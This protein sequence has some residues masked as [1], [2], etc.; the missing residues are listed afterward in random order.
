M[1]TRRR[2]LVIV[3]ALVAAIVGVLIFGAVSAKGD[4]GLVSASRDAGHP[5]TVVRLRVDCGFCF[6]PCRG[7]R[8]HRHPAGFAKGPC[9]LDGGKEVP[10]SFAVSLLPQDR[11]EDL[12]SCEIHHHRSCPRPKAAPRHRP[13][14]YL[15]DALPPPGGNN[16]ESGDLPRY[17]LRFRIPHLPA[18]EYSYVLW[19][20][21]CIAGPRGS[22]V[23]DPLSATWRLRVLP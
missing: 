12:L 21:A 17:L 14:T 9:M 23:V 6:P 16:P 11:A 7:P 2:D 13:F 1:D 8:G 10:R 15:G 18:G 19:C 5:D 4:V 22:L 3:S 20:D